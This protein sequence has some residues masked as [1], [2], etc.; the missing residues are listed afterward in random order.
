MP[1][2]DYRSLCALFA[3]GEGTVS[4]SHF[5]RSGIAAG[6]VGDNDSEF[7]LPLPPPASD[8]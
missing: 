6:A 7:S 2:H 8:I 5:A 4:L 1:K 3:G